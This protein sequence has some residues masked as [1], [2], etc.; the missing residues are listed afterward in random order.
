VAQTRLINGSRRV[1]KNGDPVKLHAT[2]KNSFDY[3][4]LGDITIGTST[5][6]VSPGSWCVINLLNTV[7]WND[8][9]NKPQRSPEIFVSNTQPSSSGL[10][11]GDIWINP[12]QN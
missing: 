5:Q 6:Q 2:K 12:S 10:L 3:S 11:P 8:V 4:N 7:E 9:L 1:I